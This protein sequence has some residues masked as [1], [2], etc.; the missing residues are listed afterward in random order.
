MEEVL[1]N[2][3]V[4]EANVLIMRTAFANAKDKNKKAVFSLFD[5]ILVSV[6]LTERDNFNDLEPDEEFSNKFL[7][8]G[9]LEG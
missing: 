4:E 1:K 3:H 5:C 6:L 8:M 9:T 2:Q 7:T